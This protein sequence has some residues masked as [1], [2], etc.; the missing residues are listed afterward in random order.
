[1]TAATTPNRCDGVMVSCVDFGALS[2]CAEILVGWLAWRAL[3]ERTRL[4]ICKGASRAAYCHGKQ[5][6]QA[7]MPRFTVAGGETLFDAGCIF[8]PAVGELA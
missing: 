3:L 7:Q 8:A 4:V 2:S 5:A 1:M 6:A